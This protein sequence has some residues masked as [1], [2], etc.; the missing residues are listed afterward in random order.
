MGPRNFLPWPCPVHTP[1][2]PNNCPR[3]FPKNNVHLMAQT[4][5]DGDPP[6]SASC[7]N[8][9]LAGTLSSPLAPDH[10]L[11]QR[12]CMQQ[13]GA[14]KKKYAWRTT[15]CR[16]PKTYVF[17]LRAL[18]PLGATTVSVKTVRRHNRSVVL[19]NF[20]FLEAEKGCLTLF[21]ATFGFYVVEEGRLGWHRLA[22][23]LGRINM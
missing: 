12:T 10:D 3:K 14:G 18:R 15:Q 20:V 17:I 2:W 21:V 8:Q 22:R 5:P 11:P 6:P 4:G 13:N 19:R 9:H 16:D 7:W 1:R 23:N